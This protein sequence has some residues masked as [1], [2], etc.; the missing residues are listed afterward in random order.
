MS[1]NYDN[2]LNV[3]GS[4]KGFEQASGHSI[5]SKAAPLFSVSAPVDVS[6]M[7]LAFVNVA[8]GS[9]IGT[10]TMAKGASTVLLKPYDGDTTAAA[11]SGN[12]ILTATTV[13]SNAP[14]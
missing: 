13:Y 4:L 7:E 3:Q 8:D 12:N 5:F 10:Q 1:F 11:A 9:T 6:A 2:A 14:T